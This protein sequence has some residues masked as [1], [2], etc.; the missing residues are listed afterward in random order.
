MALEF[1]Q[2]LCSNLMNA[3]QLDLVRQDVATIKGQIEGIQKGSRSLKR[4]ASTTPLQPELIKDLPN[5]PWDDYLSAAQ[6]GSGEE[7]TD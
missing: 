5:H 3:Q 1:S 6:T 7:V 2:G 4:A